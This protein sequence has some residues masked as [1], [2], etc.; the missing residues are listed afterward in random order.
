M[1]RHGLVPCPGV[2]TLASASREIRLLG[3]GNVVRRAAIAAVML[4]LGVNGTL[5]QTYPNRPVKVVVPFPAGGGTD[6]LTRFITKGMEQ[7]LGQPF[8]VENRGGAGTTLGATAVARSEPDG[9]TIMVGTASTFAAAPGLYKRLAYDPN[10]DFAPVMMF[11]TVP[12]VLVV[13]PS[14]GVRSVSELVALAKSKPGELPY[15]SAGVGAVHHIFCEMFMSMT[16]I[17]MKHVPYRGGGP[18]LNDVVA[19]HVPVYFADAGPAAS[20]IKSGKLIALGVTTAT[21][22]GHMPDVPTL[23]EAG[24]T[25]Y[26][27]NTWQMMAGPARMPEPVVARLNAALTEVMRT[28]EAQSYFSGLGMQTATGTPADAAEHVRKESARWTALIRKIG[29]SIE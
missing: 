22:A 25:G 20:L 23:H 14:L 12:F 18:A 2:I 11:A 10:K 28:P 8:I 16:G 27:A 9:Y 13:H 1:R 29:I 5:A 24:V 4:L 19:G 7:R 6:A 26:E 21:R 17:S 3:E 15:A